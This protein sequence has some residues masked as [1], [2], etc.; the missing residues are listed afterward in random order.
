MTVKSEIAVIVLA[1]GKGKRIGGAKALHPLGN[2]T[3]L[4]SILHNLRSAGL[5]EQIV[6]V[7]QG[8]FDCVLAVSGDATVVVNP[9]LDA[10]MWSALQVGMHKAEDVKGC[11]VIPVDYPFVQIATFR[12]LTGA[13]LL[14]PDSIVLPH[15]KDRGG[16]PV[17][18]P[19]AWAKTIPRL[20]VDGGLRSAIRQSGL[21]ILRLPVDDPGVL[22]NINEKADLR[23]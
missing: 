6:V 19:F 20:Q 7:S 3:F 14:N 1:G 15:Y 10:D 2:S 23:D 22:R 18:L 16:H 9:Q 4:E 21:P 13:F 5:N 12:Q 8:I 11:M 17:V